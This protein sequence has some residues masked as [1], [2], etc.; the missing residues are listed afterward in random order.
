MPNHISNHAKLTSFTDDWKQEEAAF[1]ELQAL[2][3]TEDSPFDFNVL[4]PYPEPYKSLDDAAREA[5]KRGVKWADL[6]KDGYNSGGYEWC[7][8]NWGTKWNAYDIA[9]DYDTVSFQTA[10]STPEPIWQ[11]LSKR[12]PDMQLEVE[13]ADEDRGANCGRLV[14]RNG[15]LKTYEDM[16]GLPHSKLFARAVIA[17]QHAAHY[18]A[19]LHKLRETLKAQK[20]ADAAE[21]DAS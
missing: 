11:E 4:I 17:E 5:E 7:N 12:F 10:W 16:E 8:A 9:F 19:E 14:Y 18:H 6:P 1:K 2:M 3:K 13:Y 15:E 20:V 21:G